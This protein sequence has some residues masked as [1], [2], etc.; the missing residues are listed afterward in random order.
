MSDVH[1]PVAAIEHLGQLA[2]LRPLTPPVAPTMLWSA[3]VWSSLAS[4][5][6]VAR[7]ASFLVIVASPSV[8]PAVLA[9]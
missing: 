5:T 3:E 4:I 7:P 8:L 2:W 9:G 6:S 1:D